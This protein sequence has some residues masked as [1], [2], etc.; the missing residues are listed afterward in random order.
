MFLGSHWDAQTSQSGRQKDRVRDLVSH[1]VGPSPRT[2]NQETRLH[3]SCIRMWV[4]NARRFLWS[5]LR[6]ASI[7]HRLSQAG[8]STTKSTMSGGTIAAALYAATFSAPAALGAVPE[9]TEKKAHH[10]K[11]GKGFTNPWDSWKEFT[12]RN[13]LW[14]MAT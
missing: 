5:Y 6:R 8:I 3:G 4:F 11:N 13:I 1:H 7:K 14:S 12:A 2:N 10:L 9:D